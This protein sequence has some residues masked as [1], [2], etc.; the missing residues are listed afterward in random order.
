MQIFHFN[1]YSVTARNELCLNSRTLFVVL[2]HDYTGGYQ[3]LEMIVT[4]FYLAAE[5]ER[6]TQARFYAKFSIVKLVNSHFSP[7]VSK[8]TKNKFDALLLGHRI[9]PAASGCH[10]NLASQNSL[11][12]TH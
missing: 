1:S 4:T 6:F 3:S 8:H 5:N 12:R 2:Y 7:R 11:F 9:L 10:Y